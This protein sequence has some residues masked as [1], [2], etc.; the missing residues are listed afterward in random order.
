MGSVNVSQSAHW[1][2]VFLVCKTYG[3]FGMMVLE[4]MSGDQYRY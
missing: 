4:E 3:N 1:I 2:L